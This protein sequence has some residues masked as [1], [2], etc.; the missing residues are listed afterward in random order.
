[1]TKAGRLQMIGLAAVLIAS[2]SG[3]R[4]SPARDSGDFR[5]RARRRSWPASANSCVCRPPG[6]PSEYFDAM[7]AK[8]HHTGSPFQIELADYVADRFRSFGLDVSRY[9]Y[10]ALIPWPGEQRVELVAP[11]AQ[12]IA[13]DEETLPGDSYAAQPG[14]LPPY[15]VD[16]RPPETS[17]AIWST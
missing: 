16:L 4:R 14:I 12:A 3:T 13:I 15:N 6:P 2:V 5:R 17:Q 11:V 9:E 8:P 1:M 10:R 7:T